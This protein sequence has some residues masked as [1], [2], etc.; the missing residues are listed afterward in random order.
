MYLGSNLTYWGPS[1]DFR[2]ISVRTWNVCP[3]VGPVRHSQTISERQCTRLI[4]SLFEFLECFQRGRVTL[5]L[6]DFF[7]PLATRTYCSKIRCIL[8]IQGCQCPYAPMS[9]DQP[10]YP[11][12]HSHLIPWT[13]QKNI[14]SCNRS[15][16]WMLDI[17]NLNQ[18]FLKNFWRNLRNSLSY[19]LL[20]NNCLI[21][22]LPGSLWATCPKFSINENH[23]FKFRRS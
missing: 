11:L 2:E 5:A 16:R 8:L 18:N 1:Q 7:R 14:S 6:P 22:L 12:T 20:L 9:I 13:S 10:S 4:K 17:F 19:S 15:P 3:M 23:R 21:N